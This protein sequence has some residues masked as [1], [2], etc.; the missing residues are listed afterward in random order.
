MGP[1]IVGGIIV[2]AVAIAVVLIIVMGKSD[3]AATTTSSS[4]PTNYFV[5]SGV[6]LVG[7]TSAQFN[8][9]AQAQFSATVQP[10]FPRVFPFSARSPEAGNA[11][12]AAHLISCA[13][14]SRPK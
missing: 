11:F 6:S 3:T 7:V 8:A 4:G 2:V 13:H 12:C 9:A 1:A 14:R 10:P 5:T